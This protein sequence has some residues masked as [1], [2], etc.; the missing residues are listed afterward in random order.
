MPSQLHLISGHPKLAYSKRGIL[1]PPKLVLPLPVFML[2][3]LYLPSFKHTRYFFIHRLFNDLPIRISPITSPYR[4]VPIKIRCLT[5]SPRPSIPSSLSNSNLPSL[6][7][8]LP[9]LLL[10]LPSFLSARHCLFR[11]VFTPIVLTGHRPRFPKLLPCHQH[12]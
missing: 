6:T 12:R 10:R 2:T 1:T 9:S 5:P 4:V 8:F 7:P 3:L 11:P